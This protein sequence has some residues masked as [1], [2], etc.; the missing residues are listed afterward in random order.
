MTSTALVKQSPV[1]HQI[2]ALVPDTVS[3]LHRRL[4]TLDQTRFD[5][6][7]HHC[8]CISYLAQSEVIETPSPVIK[9][10]L[11]RRGFNVCTS[12]SYD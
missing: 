5:N 9:Q 4:V 2:Y 11:Y 3:N 1:P 12:L 7:Q 10:V 6:A 8:L